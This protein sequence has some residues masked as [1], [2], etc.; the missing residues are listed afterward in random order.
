M[1][2][3]QTGPVRDRLDLAVQIAREAG[4]LTLQHFRRRDLQVDRKA[5]KSPVTIADRAAEE[6]LRERITEHYPNDA[7]LGEEYGTI[8]GTSGY[9]WILDPIDGTKSF[10]HGVPLYTNLIAVLHEEKPVLGVINAPALAEMVFAATGGGCWFTTGESQAPQPAHVSKVKTLSE[11]LLLTSEVASFSTHRSGDALNMYLRLQDSVRFAR[12]WGDG[13]GYLM[14]ATG[15]ADVT[16]DPIMN[17]WDVAPLQ[18][19]I[20]EAGGH[21]F[22]W[23]GQPTIRAG[24]SIATNGQLAEQVLAFTRSPIN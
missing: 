11:A 19:I 9:Q 15:R 16:I 23:N 2:K 3:D 21:F 13:Y 6:L 4:A 14:V 10:I 8:E 22:D 18:T 17:L 7:V 20:E 24:E 1:S 5:D 12:T